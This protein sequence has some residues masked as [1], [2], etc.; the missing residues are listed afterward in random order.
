MKI[1]DCD[2]AKPSVIYRPAIKRQDRTG[3]EKQTLS[4]PFPP[5]SVY[6]LC[7]CSLILYRSFSYLSHIFIIEPG[8]NFE[9]LLKDRSDRP[10]KS[11]F[12]CLCFSFVF[13]LTLLE[14]TALLLYCQTK[15]SNLQTFKLSNF[16][17]PKISLKYL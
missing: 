16:V 14:S 11:R 12:Y 3:Y 8:G 17:V 5:L 1:E 4:V 15:L 10:D 2:H 13:P 6:L 9:E 7:I